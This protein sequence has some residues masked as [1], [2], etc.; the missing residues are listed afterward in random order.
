MTSRCW[1]RGWWELGVTGSRP[2]EAQG[3]G[4]HHETEEQ[5]DSPATGGYRAAGAGE[6]PDA[7]E[8]G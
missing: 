5:A 1:G 7:G 2:E 3:P 6:W 4:G 8:G